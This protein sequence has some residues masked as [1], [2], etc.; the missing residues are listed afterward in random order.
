MD[1]VSLC[2]RSY[3][4]LQK[5]WL[6]SHKAQHR[7]PKLSYSLLVLCKLLLNLTCTVIFVLV[8]IHVPM[9]VLYSVMHIVDAL[10]VQIVKK[11]SLA[12]IALAVL[13]AMLIVKYINKTITHFINGT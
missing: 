5:P 7:L 12:Q 3:I 10:H 1:A 13:C 6:P 2:R 8:R 11:G 9:V 4:A